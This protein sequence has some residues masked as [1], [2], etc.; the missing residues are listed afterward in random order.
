M[1]DEKRLMKNFI[2]TLFIVSVFS[3]ANGQYS[4]LIIKLKDK[5]NSSYNLS[6]PSQYLSQKA[7]TRRTRFNIPTDST[8]L[9]I[10][11]AYIESISKVENVKI[12]SSS[13]WLNQVLIETTDAA[14]INKINSFPFVNSATPAGFAGK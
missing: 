6:N 12:L 14:A 9:P 5:A 10:T 7:I 13:K 4:R 1:L 8:D 2:L 3:D 11:T